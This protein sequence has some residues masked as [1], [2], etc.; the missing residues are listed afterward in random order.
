MLVLPDGM[1]A[2]AREVQQ[3]QAAA[4]AQPAG[5]ADATRLAGFTARVV[6]LVNLVLVYR[7]D[8][9]AAAAAGAAGSAGH[10]AHAAA[11][12]PTALQ[13]VAAA[14]AWLCALCVRCRCPALLRQLL[15][16]TTS[17]SDVSDA[18]AAIDALLP[19]GV[20]GTAAAAG[21]AELLGALADW[22]AAAG[23]TWQLSC[24][25]SSE[26][27]PL[28]LAAALGPGISRAAAEALVALVGA[29]AAQECWRGARAA[30]WTPR[31]VATAASNAALTAALGEAPAC[32]AAPGPS[33]LGSP[34]GS[35]EARAGDRPRFG[36]SSSAKARAAQK[37]DEL[38]AQEVAAQAA[39]AHVDLEMVLQ[40]AEKK[41]D[42]GGSLEGSPTAAAATL[43]RGQAPPASA[44]Q[45][46]AW[47]QRPMP[48]VA[49]LA[50]GG[51]AVLVALGVVAAL[52]AGI[53][54]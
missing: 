42:G 52:R 28:H 25:G 43:R 46:A 19:A 50:L 8:A 41:G 39:A 3:L 32:E 51:A 33:R 38:A 53:Y 9:A 44:E 16:A 37:L 40:A 23:H 21:D 15:P 1:E 17:A 30:G 49:L 48:P 54:G 24:V 27:T 5:G 2:E 4:E 36:P 26:L 35:G 31:Q 10:A 6:R 18:V 7:E 20:L 47:Q 45:L 29:A 12:P 13:R 22:A 34:Q 11:Y 14:A